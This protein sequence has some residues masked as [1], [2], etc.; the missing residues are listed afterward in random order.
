VRWLVLVL[1][2]ALAWADT[3]GLGDGHSG[4]AVISTATV[5]NSAVLLQGGADAGA[6]AIDVE[7]AGEFSPG[8]VVMLH[9]TQ[10]AMAIDSGTPGPIDLSVLGVGRFELVRVTSV[11]GA[12]LTLGAPL[13]QGFP[14][15]LTQVV[16][17][18][19]YRS[20]TIT[21]SGVV[22][23]AP[24]NGSTGGIVAFLVQGSV[25]NS[26]AISAAHAGFRGGATVN[27]GGCPA[28]AAA[29]NALDGPPHARK[30]EGFVSGRFGLMQLARGNVANGGGGGDSCNAGG[31]GG[32]NAGRGGVGG[33]TTGAGG[34]NPYGGLGGSAL[35]LAPFSRLPFGGGG[36]AGHDNMGSS[37]RGGVGGGVIYV[38]ARRVSGGVISA[39]GESA[40][41]S[42]GD[43]GMGSDGAG[44]G[45][46]GG[47]VMVLVAGG[48]GCVQLTATGGNGGNTP[49]FAFTTGPVGPGGGGGG[50]WA[51]LQDDGSL[52]CPTAT[53]GG[54][55]G[56]QPD[57]MYPPQYG[58][59]PDAGGQP[60]YSG[61]VS[62]LTSPFDAGS[63][64]EQPADGG[65]T[66]AYEVRCGCGAPSLQGLALALVAMVLGR[67]LAR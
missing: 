28:P 11:V 50:G 39:S 37:S 20:L 7:D 5:I 6:L 25:E 38:R 59:E 67:R 60:T 65:Q 66:H 41:A 62:H 49:E 32:G 45:G 23:A 3:L 51:F 1:F 46:A 27:T 55:S 47:T 12:R 29:E 19:E 35:S 33:W 17:V 53:E 15:G 58:S 52:S 40:S 2:P 43:G 10:Q 21:P 4:D 56:V 18:P 57:P 63:P 26:G 34:A 42:I 61:S 14:A 36:G 8:Q 9:Q 54:H 64:L 44:G 31:G 16:T 13:E 30:G 22:A 48:L 24:W